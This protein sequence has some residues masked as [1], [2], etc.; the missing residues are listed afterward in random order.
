MQRL[1][2]LMFQSRRVD[3]IK[4]STNT[5][6]QQVIDDSFFLSKSSVEKRKANESNNEK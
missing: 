6:L 3:V 1:T 2:Y 4:F 5:Q